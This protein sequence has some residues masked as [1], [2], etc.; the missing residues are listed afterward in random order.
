MTMATQNTPFWLEIK[1][2]YIDANLD[3]VLGYLEKNSKQPEKD[4]FFE[5]TKAL[6]EGRVKELLLE[7]S[8]SS[9][10]TDNAIDKEA[11]LPKL[12]ILGAFLLIQGRSCDFTV[13]ESLFF[14]L[15][16]L[17][18]IIPESYTEDLCDIAIKCLTQ[19]ELIYC[20][21]SWNELS[22]EQLEII[23][24]KIINASRFSEDYSPAAWFQGKGS[25]KIEKGSIDLY[26]KNRDDSVYSKFSP[27][28]IIL[29][30]T[31]KVQV[32][33]SDRIILSE[34]DDI[35]VMNAFTTEVM[36]VQQK[37]IPSPIKLLKRYSQGDQVVVHYLGQ[38]SE[39]NLQVE[40]LDGEYEKVVGIVPA[41]SNAFRNIYT[42]EIVGK[43]LEPGVYFNAVYKGGTREVFDISSEF[44]KQMLE[45]TI[46]TS[47]EIKAVLK[48]INPQTGLMTWWTQDGYPAYVKHSDDPGTYN[49]GD[50]AYVFIT[51]AGSNGYVYATVSDSCEEQVDEEESRKYCV[52]GFP[53]EEEPVFS[54]AP[55]S[56]V[57]D[58]LAIKG[59]LR[60]LFHY[61]QSQEQAA[62]R[63]RVL[64]LCRIL[65]LMTDD[66]A[67]LQFIS[68]AS[69]YLRTLVNFA[70]DEFD[71]IKPL[72]V[73][74]EIELNPSVKRWQA[75]ISILQAYGKDD[76]EDFLSGIIHDENETDALLIKL[77]KLVQSSNRIDDVYPAIKTVI[78]SEITKF[79]AVETAGNADFENA[80]GPNL[81]VENSRVEFKTSFFFAPENAYEKNQE[82]NIF[83]DLCSFLNTSEG[84]TLYM[85][86]NDHGGINGL[87]LDLEHLE[88]K[89]IGT[90]KGIDGYIRYIIDR[91]KAYFDLD[92]RI[93][94]HL[95]P[96]Y[97]EKVVVIRVD[98]Y[99]HGVVEFE[100]VPYIRNN[101]ESV[102]MSQALRR[103]IEAKK[104]TADKEKSKNV[105]A[106][107]EAIRE[108]KTV[109]FH[110]YASLNSADVRKR[111]V[112]PFAFIGENKF[113]WCYD[114]DDDKNKL[115]RL[116]RI[117]SV[118]IT[119]DPWTKKTK[120]VKGKTD[121]FHFS[122]DK[123]IPIK[124]Q[125]DLMAKNLLVEE[126]PDA[127]SDLSPMG[128]NLWLLD[129]DVYQIVG[130]G[131]FY[132]GLM[133]HIEII[134]A[135]ELKE[136]AKEFIAK[137][138]GKL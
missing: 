37:T 33:T 48:S 23:A 11:L 85:G 93:H 49:V 135:P 28:L 97:D 38:D 32:P 120:H 42:A 5:Q 76:V 89:I 71:K 79:L 119:K 16:L 138:Q 41:K 103:Q 55:T 78:K 54:K 81:G 98:P 113:I 44:T 83:R 110:N 68:L 14:F 29:D 86:V 65:S 24:H 115:F 126:Y 74:G 61:Q 13:K 87:D 35:D 75:I 6:L 8:T 134:D 56:H 22:S 4:S 40:T 10:E 80:S 128:D 118:E 92:V 82:K 30:K 47:I 26:E 131:R 57:V 112:E 21:F 133:D 17:M 59:L 1:T 72:S 114:L 20:G 108:E 31:I 67:A 77:A 102:K 12:K 99:E 106:I 132:V 129:S 100:G 116:S 60:L 46:R 19:N 121:I 70:N 45:N 130:A 64:C 18:K 51:G 117:G 88:K 73:D 107:I 101:N 66:T 7:L 122:G 105:I 127:V 69:D 9:V 62:Y 111:N 15:Y 39:G 43:Y 53:L 27:S 125:L 136:Y 2:E 36:R 50:M 90:Y 25:A 3:K 109:V 91:A 63:Y 96:A 123:P 104:L 52:D 137:N 58:E 34:A 94:F 95:D 124:L 84:G